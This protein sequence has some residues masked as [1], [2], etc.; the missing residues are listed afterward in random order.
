MPFSVLLN[1]CVFCCVELY[2]RL[3]QQLAPRCDFLVSNPPY[4]TSEEMLQ[5]EPE[6]FRW[7]SSCWNVSHKCHWMSIRHKDNVCPQ[8][9]ILP[10]GSIS[11]DG[12]QTNI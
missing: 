10:E 9:E 1:M 2:T 11:T 7:F 5:L 3:P 6:I 12:K 4:V 8:V